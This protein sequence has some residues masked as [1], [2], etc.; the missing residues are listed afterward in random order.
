MT[1]TFKELGISEEILKV[2]KEEGFEKPSEIQNKT[3]PLVLDGKDVIGGSATGSGKTLAFAA[4]IIEKTQHKNGIQALILTPTREL[5]EQVSLAIK[6]FSKYKHLNII[7]IYGGVSIIPQIRNLKSADIVVGT[8]GRILD[9]L[10]RKT[11]VLGS[12][13]TLVLDE[14]DRML[15]MGFIN[16]V[17]TIIKA[18]PKNRQTLLFSATIYDEVVYIASKYMNSPIEVAA[19]NRVDPR[20]L[21]Q[22]YYDVSDDMKFSLLIHLLKKEKSDLIMIFCNTRRN[23]DFIAR[24]LNN[25]GIPSVSVHGGYPQAKRNRMM[26]E[27]HIKKIKV[28]VCTDVAARGLDIEGISHVYNYE[29]PKEAKDYIHRIGRTARAGKDGKAINLLSRR[30][31]DNFKKIDDDSSLNLVRME[32]PTIEKIFI[33]SFNNVR[34]FQRRSPRARFGREDNRDY[35]KNSQG[36]ERAPFH[37]NRDHTHRGSRNKQTKGRRFHDSNNHKKNQKRRRY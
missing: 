16:D 11:I 24:N 1:K 30:D 12:L 8:P 31:Y 19:K 10:D 28:L 5:A 9:H 2:I 33:K 15:D 17:L 18:C 27:F 22:I 7:S 29:I 35:K 21:N 32:L 20:K 37:R 25:T 26:Q 13:K 3:I 4:G 23:T 36:Q 14:A 6:H 34:R